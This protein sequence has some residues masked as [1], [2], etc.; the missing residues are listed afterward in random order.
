MRETVPGVFGL[1]WPCGSPM[2]S[3]VFL[4]F[5]AQSALFANMNGYI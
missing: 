3:R 5:C 4:F 1:V 2:R